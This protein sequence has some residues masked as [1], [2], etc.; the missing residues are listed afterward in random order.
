MYEYMY[1]YVS[2]KLDK[3]S[4]AQTVNYKY[5][6]FHFF[7]NNVK[8][9]YLLSVYTTSGQ[10]LKQGKITSNQRARRSMTVVEVDMNI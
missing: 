2:Y 5:C 1:L 9:N 6:T 3:A 10:A 8:W 7:V 4:A